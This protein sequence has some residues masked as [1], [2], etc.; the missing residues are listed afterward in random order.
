M[1]DNHYNGININ[2]QSMSRVTSASKADARSYYLYKAANRQS[3]VILDAFAWS[4]AIRDLKNKR[5]VRE[6]KEKGIDE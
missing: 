4:R 3:F 1:P 5:A 2:D 6:R